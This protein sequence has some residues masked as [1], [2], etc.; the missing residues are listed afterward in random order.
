MVFHGANVLSPLPSR[1]RGSGEGS[2]IVD[3]GLST[4]HLNPLP[5]EEGERRTNSCEQI[6]LRLG[7]LILP[8][9]HLMRLGATEHPSAANPRDDRVSLLLPS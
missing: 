9:T 3:R 5:F 8:F 6:S 2:S 7:K 4:P 1:G